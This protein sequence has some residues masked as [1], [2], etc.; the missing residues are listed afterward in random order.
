MA[1]AT[2]DIQVTGTRDLKRATDNMIS[3]GTVSRKLVSDYD[4][5]GASE[6][7][8]I[9]VVRQLNSTISALD[10]ALEDGRITQSRYNRAVEQAE[11][12]AQ[13]QILT[14]KEL[15]RQEK[16]NRAELERKEKALQ[17]VKDE[18]H[19]ARMS[20]DQLYAA[21]TRLKKAQEAINLAVKTGGMDQDLA[22]KRI[23]DLTRDYNLWVQAVKSGNYEM[24][25]SGNS[26]ARFNDEVFRTQQ[27]LKRFASVGLQQAGYQVGDFIVQVQSGQSAL[28]AF[29][30]QASQLAGIFGA[31]GA[32]IG[33]GIAATTGLILVWQSL[34]F[35]G[36]AAKKATEDLDNALKNLLE[37]LRTYRDE[38]EAMSKGI[39][40][41]EL[42]AGR[43]LSGA[44]AEVKR[45]QDE[46]NRL[47]K[48]GI[49]ATDDSSNP[50]DMSGVETEQ[51][52]AAKAK[53][54]E[55]LNV[56]RETQ[57]MEYNKAAD[58][59]A[60]RDKET[61]EA[62]ERTR[63]TN[64]ANLVQSLKYE[65]QLLHD[66]YKA[67]IDALNNAT[68]EELAVLG[69]RVAARL[70]IE[71]G[72]SAALEA[73]NEKDRAAAA[74]QDA[75]R[76]KAVEGL[77]GQLTT[78]TQQLEQ[79]KAKQIEIIA[80]ASEA[81][82]AIVGGKY[83]ALLALQAEY[84]ARMAEI[85]DKDKPNRP[86]VT[87]ED[88]LIAKLQQLQDSLLLE[89][90][91][92]IKSYERKQEIL[93]EALQ[94]EYLARE[95]YT[96]LTLE[97]ERRKNGELEALEIAVQQTKVDAVLGGLSAVLN[98][99]ANGNERLLKAARV[100]SAAQA[101][102]NTYLGASQVLADPLTPWWVKF[103]AASGI[104]ATGLGF[105]NA[106]KSGSPSGSSGAGSSASSVSVP[107]TASPAK[108]QRVFIEGLDRS[109]LISGEQLSNIFEALYKENEDRGF[110]FEV[111]R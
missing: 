9:S 37:T 11:R 82:L 40:L 26:F 7:R 6:I 48:L 103:G 64:T 45:L 75:Q 13:A 81:E 89:E 15:I 111:A 28:V 62:A 109:S 5:L 10:K 67:D 96:R 12:N 49:G 41:N 80:L 38:K 110:V 42:I 98:A 19:R 105:V 94:K 8:R 47:T 44:Q 55:A 101:L 68:D 72:Y 22:R 87:V 50:E 57:I 33:A 53:L 102:V 59:R 32:V 20:Y 3:L 51:L 25:N 108:P 71:E 76:L 91:A 63:A 17:K 18:A 100:A 66:K 90:E 73:L 14:D 97:L 36:Q 39:T 52:K 31:Y 60:Q 83:G 78:E 46:V 56:L 92:I 88:P 24:I 95:E 99:A 107:A 106:I 69:G 35:E 2:F 104:V 43:G 70:K 54:Q 27:R 16:A 93:E 1:N 74:A 21:E 23:E 4:A 85:L 58:E 34:D 29:G 84:E 30:Q 61:L 65:S 86:G 77:L 79:W